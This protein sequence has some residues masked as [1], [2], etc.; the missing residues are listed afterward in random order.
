M[1]FTQYMRPNGRKVFTTINRP[2]EIEAKAREIEAV[3]YVFETEVLMN[4]MCSFE[5]ITLPSEE[6]ISHE[7]CKNGPPVLDAVDKL[8]NVAHTFLF[9]KIT[10]VST[11]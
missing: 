10:K 9:P 8:V 11:K 4:G 1:N 3:G 2:P 6:V 5:C 7:I